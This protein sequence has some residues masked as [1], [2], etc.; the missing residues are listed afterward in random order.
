YVA[1]KEGRL[2]ILKATLKDPLL[3][4]SIARYRKTQTDRRK[5][6]GLAQLE[7]LLKKGTR[8]SW[9]REPRNITDLLAKAREEGRKTNSVHRS[10]YAA[11]KG[12]LVY[13]L[14]EETKAKITR[15]VQFTYEDDTRHIDAS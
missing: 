6:N 4:E 7:A 12:L 2:D 13:E 8:L 9:L 11:I 3:S 15:A 5:L 10:L 1:D 14:G